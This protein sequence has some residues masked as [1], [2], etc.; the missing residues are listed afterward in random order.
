MLHGGIPQCY[1]KKS[2]KL[3]NAVLI[4]DQIIV[5]TLNKEFFLLIA[6]CR[7]VN[8]TTIDTDGTPNMKPSVIINHSH[9][10]SLLEKI[11]SNPINASNTA[12]AIGTS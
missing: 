4:E 12:N 10:A 7:P 8:P 5:T 2:P 6:Y 1:S 9:S 3:P 11:H